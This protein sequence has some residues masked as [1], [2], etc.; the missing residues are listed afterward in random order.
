MRGT[1]ITDSQ[2]EAAKEFLDGRHNGDYKPE[3]DNPVS[4]KYKDLVAL[5]AW[6]GAIRYQSGVDGVGTR[7]C[8]ASTYV[9]EAA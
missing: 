1:D 7:E 9:R 8:P 5:V 2:M 3:L 6:Y 4:L